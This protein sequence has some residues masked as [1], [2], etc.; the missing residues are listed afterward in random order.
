MTDIKLLNDPEY[1]WYHRDEMSKI[2]PRVSIRKSMG[3]KIIDYE[4]LREIN[5]VKIKP[6]K[7]RK[8][9]WDSLKFF[10][11]EV[12]RTLKDSNKKQFS[13]A[14]RL[15]FETR[16]RGVCAICGQIN[17]YGSSSNGYGISQLHHIVPNGPIDDDNN[18]ATLCMHC[19]QVVHQLLYLDVR[20]KYAR[21]L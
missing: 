4:K 10:V 20:W 13:P 5:S 15:H 14:D 21:P 9:D 6:C 11:N 3:I 19:H 18:V 17:R 1:R 8:F 2:M 16:D 7:T 12:P